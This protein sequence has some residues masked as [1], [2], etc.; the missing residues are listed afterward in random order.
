[1][2]K[3][4]SGMTWS[5]RRNLVAG[6]ITAVILAVFG[7]AII[8][9]TFGPGEPLVN[10]IT[11]L[12]ILVVIIG[13]EGLLITQLYKAVN[14]LEQQM[15]DRTKKTEVVIDISQRLSAI[16]DLKA[17]MQE[18]VTVTKETFDYYHVHIYLLDDQGE[19]LYVAEGYGQAGEE[20]IRR[21]HKIPV[22]APKSL[23]ARAYRERQ[24][25]TVENVQADP[26]WLP[27]PIL[28][29]TRSEMAI[30]VVLVNEVVGILN[31]QSKR[32]AG[33]TRED[34]KTLQALANQVA[35][36]IHNTRL[37][38]QMQEVRQYQELT[39][40]NYLA[41]VEQVAKGDLTARLT[42]NGHGENDTLSTLGQNLNNMVESLGEMTSQI[43]EATINVAAAS[44]EIMSA[45]AQQAT[46]ASEQSAAISEISTTIDE[47]K[48]IVE[49]AFAKAQAVAE[50][51]QRTRDVA[52]AG[53]RA[54]S[55]TVE[56]MSQIKD[57]VEGIAENI[58]A[59]SEQ[60][61]QIGEIIATVNDIAAQSNLLALNASVEAARAGEH[62]KGFA[63][64]AVEVRNLAEQSKQA[65]AQVKS[66]LNEIQRATNAA[67]MATEEGTKGVDTGV[68]LTGQAGETIQRLAAS[69]SE[70]A[71][72][73]QQILASVQQQTTGVEQIAL[74]MQNI[75]QA[76]VQNLASTR[77]AEK[78]AQDLAALAQQ[79]ESLVARYRLN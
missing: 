57:R 51:A 24:I 25:V 22:A 46:R 4:F 73:A 44:T 62:G 21:R 2:M 43:R 16:L 1:M 30:P 28:P 53:Q 27:N 12:L 6:Y 3:I 77:Q 63:V 67:V 15:A 38:S 26:T 31:V 78:A 56:G 33:L 49:Q 68:D 23:V 11:A 9:L 66:I 79:M 50:Q 48:M 47:V 8:I 40:S 54:V 32:V 70:S 72:A 60:T 65:T 20:L 35:I 14:R 59:L 42:F 34:E 64:V 45:T 18:V 52:Q 13:L 39:V 29:E 71:S 19:F 10:P 75:N 55:G 74:A 61:Q 7:G 41:F 58:L 36:A 69:I 76:T 37:F 5:I 17:L